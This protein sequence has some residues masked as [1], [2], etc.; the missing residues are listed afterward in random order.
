MG[1]T[2][3]QLELLDSEWMELIVK[4][5]Q[6]GIEKEEIREFLL[7]NGVKKLAWKVAE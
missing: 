6:M 7:K 4:A 1:K 3:V 2:R 5:K